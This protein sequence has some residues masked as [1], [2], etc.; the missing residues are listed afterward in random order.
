M[1]PLAYRMR[2]ILHNMG[3]KEPP[4][5]FYLAFRPLIKLDREEHVKLVLNAVKKYK[6]RLVILDPLFRML[7]GDENSQKDINKVIDALFKIR[8]CGTVIMLLAHLNTTH[9][10]NAQKDIDSQVRGSSLIVGSYDV[11]LALRKYTNKTKHIDLTVRNRNGA[12][13][14]FAVF[15]KIKNDE[16]D[17]PIDAGIQIIQKGPQK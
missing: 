5:D 6:P 2:A 14:E 7:E 13:E 10:D 1:H 11:H 3:V 9:G 8:A 16:N 4:K 15:W 17:F 12:E